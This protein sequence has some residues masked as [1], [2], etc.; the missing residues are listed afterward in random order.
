MT[1]DVAISAALVQPEQLKGKLA[2]VIDVLRATSVICTG[3]YHGADTFVTVDTVARAQREI[4]RLNKLLK[5]QKLEDINKQIKEDWTLLLRSLPVTNYTL[6]AGERNGFKID[7]FDLG[8]SPLEYTP[9]VVSGKT[10]ILTTT[11]GTL[12]IKKS[13]VADELIIA[14][15]LN[16]ETVC[17]YIRKA[18]KDVCIVCAG[19]LNEFS[20]DDALCAG[21]IIADLVAKDKNISLSDLAFAHKNMYKTLAS[22]N[23]H[24]PLKE[25]C[26][27]YTY[28]QKNGFSADLNYCLKKNTCPILPKLNGDYITL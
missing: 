2:V 25:A 10:I 6:L 3:L 24:L 4:N 21:N 28:L 8:N 1:I 13:M 22:K 20:L 9:E 23:L 17:N 12:A 27:H 5:K 18:K 7:Q 14:S 19:T 15:F 16:I 26:S 11:N